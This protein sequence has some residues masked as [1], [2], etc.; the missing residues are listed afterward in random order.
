VNAPVLVRGEFHRRYFLSFPITICIALGAAHVPIGDDLLGFISVG[1]IC[2]G[3]SFVG[4]VA[5][6]NVPLFATD[7][8]KAMDQS[9]APPIVLVVLCYFGLLVGYTELIRYSWSPLVGI[10]LFAGALATESAGLALLAWSFENRYVSPKCAY[11]AQL[12]TSRGEGSETA[13]PSPPIFG[14]P[15]LAFSNIICVLAM[16]MDNTLA[17]AGVLEVV[18]RPSQ[19]GWLLAQA[20]STFV[21]V[22]KQ[23]GMWQRLWCKFFGLLGK[24]DLTAMNSVKLTYLRTQHSCRHSSHSHTV[25]LVGYKRNRVASAASGCIGHRRAQDPQQPTVTGVAA[26]ALQVLLTDRRLVHRLRARRLVWRRA[27]HRVARRES[28]SLD[29]YGC[30]RELRPP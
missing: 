21:N 4:C 7:A 18:I 19:R 1:L 17:V 28:N 8:H 16:V 24:P 22:L 5:A 23:V 14:V 11:I 10:Y 27:V 29:G 9:S 25:G 12:A 6:L 13:P 3:L 15:E 26:R 30:R 20:I 2:L